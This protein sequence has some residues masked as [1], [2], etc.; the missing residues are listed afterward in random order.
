MSPAMLPGPQA[1]RLPYRAQ[2]LDRLCDVAGEIL[3]CHS[4]IG[5]RTSRRLPDDL[6]D[7][8]QLGQIL[9]RDPEALRQLGPPGRVAEKDRRGALRRDDGEDRVLPRE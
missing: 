8:V 3:R 2:R 1:P 5:L 7:D 4:R 6:V 9:G